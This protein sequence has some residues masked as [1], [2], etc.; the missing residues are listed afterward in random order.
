MRLD[1]RRPG[2][3]TTFV[4]SPSGEHVLQVATDADGVLV[5][6]Y[7]LHD[8]RGALVAQSAGLEEL[9]LGLTILSDRGH[10]LLSIP[11]DI[12]GVIQYR[13]YSGNGTLLTYSDGVR[14]KICPNLR[15]EGVARL[16]ARDS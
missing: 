7:H 9:P 16:W 3:S 8:D 1:N 14:T 11:P 13:L 2:T 12:G 10:L 6:A 4:D 5:I 15:M